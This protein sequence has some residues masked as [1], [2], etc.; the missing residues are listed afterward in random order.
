METELRE[1]ARSKGVTLRLERAEGAY[2]LSV[3]SDASGN[4]GAVY[5]RRERDVRES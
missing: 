4:A 5:Q 1:A 3:C 2:T